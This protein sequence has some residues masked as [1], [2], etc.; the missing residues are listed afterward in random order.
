M[1]GGDHEQP[2][3]CDLQRPTRPATAPRNATARSISRTAA[4]EDHFARLRAG[5]PRHLLTS[6]LDHRARGAAGSVDRR[7]IATHLPARAASHPSLLAGAATSHCDPDKSCGQTVIPRLRLRRPASPNVL[8]STLSRKACARPRMR[9]STTSASDTLTTGTHESAGRVLPTD[10]A[11]Q[12]PV[13]VPMQPFGLLGAAARGG[14]RL[15]DGDTMMSDMRT[16]KPD[17]RQTIAT[18]RSRA[19]FS[20]A[21]HGAASRITAPDKKSETPPDAWRSS[22]PAILDGSPPSWLAEIRH[23]HHRV[24]ALFVPESSCAI[25]FNRAFAGFGLLF[26]PR[27]VVTT[28]PKPLCAKRPEGFLGAAYRFPDCD[29]QEFSPD[30]V[31]IRK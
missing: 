17:G 1:R 16:S 25:S 5:I 3:E 18:A 15:I 24:A 22:L 26:G 23:R 13:V 6:L 21:R 29:G 14:D 30:R 2:R 20:P 9:F 11:S 12:Q 19:R 7:R 8:S 27:L 4:G 31:S 10:R 28:G